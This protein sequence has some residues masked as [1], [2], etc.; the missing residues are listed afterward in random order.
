MSNKSLEG[1]LKCNY[2]NHFVVTLHFERRCH[3]AFDV[4]DVAPENYF[5]VLN[6]Q[7]NCA[8]CRSFSLITSGII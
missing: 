6:V 8:R 5:K 2:D 4:F 7:N 3:Y 1:I